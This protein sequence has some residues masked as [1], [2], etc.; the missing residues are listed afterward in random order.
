M[1]TKKIHI[2]NFMVIVINTLVLNPF[3]FKFYY[4]LYDVITK[5]SKPKQVVNTTK[6]HCT[7]K[8]GSFK[9]KYPH[10]EIYSEKQLKDIK[11]LL[12]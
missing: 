1:F 2:L 10:R 9:R 12:T 6:N 11:I 3:T 7:I 5:T 4:I 8:V